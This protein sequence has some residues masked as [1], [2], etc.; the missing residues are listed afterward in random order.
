[1]VLTQSDEPDEGRRGIPQMASIINRHVG[2]GCHRYIVQT[3]GV[4]ALAG[5]TLPDKAEPTQSFGNFVLVNP[6]LS[7]D[8]AA[9]VKRRVLAMDAARHVKK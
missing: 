6:R 9:D 1:L 4:D 2:F 7:V 5:L 3:P 8:G